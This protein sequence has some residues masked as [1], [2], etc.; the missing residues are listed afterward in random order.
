MANDRIGQEIAHDKKILPRAKEIWGWGTPAGWKRAERRTAYFISYGAMEAGKKVLEIGCGT[1]IFTG[2]IGQSGAAVVGVDISPDFIN[3]AKNKVQAPNIT[4]RIEDVQSLSFPDNEFDTVIGSSVLHHLELVPALKEI[5]RVLKPGGRLVITEPN[6]MNPQ[7]M[8]QKNILWI[9]KLMGDSPGE[10][11][12]FR[13]ALKKVLLKTGF[14]KV[15]IRPFDFLH[16]WTPPQLIS[17]VDRF[18]RLLEKVPGI[19]EI[20]GSLVITAQK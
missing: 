12:F 9:K 20:A 13:W 5:K 17:L 1:G 6:M 8:I 3:L 4:F 19:K 11:A 7:I 2:K 14:E 10:T 15:H 18:G 16:P